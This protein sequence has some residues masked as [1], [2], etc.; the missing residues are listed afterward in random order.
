MTFTRQATVF[1]VTMTISINFVVDS[2]VVDPWGKIIAQA[3]EKESII[4]SDLDM[5]SI[6]S[7]RMQIPILTQKKTF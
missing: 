1:H 4:Y 2:S 3:S 7:V 5:E 6:K